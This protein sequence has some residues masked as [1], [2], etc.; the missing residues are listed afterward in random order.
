M[1]FFSGKIRSHMLTANSFCERTD[2]IE[3]EAES[4]PDKIKSEKCRNSIVHWVSE[5]SIVKSH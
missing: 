1:T 5:D 3:G 2:A 4:E